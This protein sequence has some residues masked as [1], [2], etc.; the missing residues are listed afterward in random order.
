M[1]RHLQGSAAQCGGWKQAVDA[2]AG[3]P[4]LGVT[5]GGEER[6]NPLVVGPGWTTTVVYEV[7]QVNPGLACLEVPPDRWQHFGQNGVPALAATKLDG[8]LP[9]GLLTLVYAR[10]GLDEN[11]VPF[12]LA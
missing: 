1:S 8:E 7:L 12:P 5:V 4:I 6:V 3:C 11:G 10:R 9:P 2:V